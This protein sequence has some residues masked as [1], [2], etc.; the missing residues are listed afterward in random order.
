M[1]LRARAD[2]PLRAY[3][4]EPTAELDARMGGRRFPGM[5]LIVAAAIVAMT[6]AVVLPP[7]PEPES[8]GARSGE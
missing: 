6:P 8:V 3:V 5:H 1:P 7:D 2:R 4:R